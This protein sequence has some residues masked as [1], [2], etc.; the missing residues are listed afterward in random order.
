MSV[1]SRKRTERTQCKQA[2]SNPLPA[3]KQAIRRA[4]FQCLCAAVLFFL[5]AAAVILLSLFSE[6]PS[7]KET[8]FIISGMICFSIFLY[9]IISFIRRFLIFQ[10]L[11]KIKF[12]TEEAVCLSCKRLSFVFQPVS[13]FSSA[14]LCV[15]LVDESENKFYY[16][17]PENSAPFDFA[18]K[19]I[20]E[21][22]IGKQLD[23]ICYKETRI[24][25]DL[26]LRK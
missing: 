16:V 1:K 11:N 2:P 24:V 3:Q 25:K 8:G 18:K 26:P 17:Y 21:A 14:V 7:S 5:F 4:M 23:I 22:C 12:S 19:Y 13:Q 10:Q 15:V 6:A 9:Y 20:Q